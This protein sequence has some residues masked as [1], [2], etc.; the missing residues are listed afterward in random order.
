MVAVG[1]WIASL[2]SMLGLPER[3][4]VR[5]PDGAVV[6]NQ[7]MWTYWYLQEGEV[8]FDPAKFVTKDGSP[9]RCC[10]STPTSRC[11]PTTAG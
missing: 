6:E 1:P 10:T 2:W 11:A 9:R 5:Q 4:D 8:E 3:I 7:P